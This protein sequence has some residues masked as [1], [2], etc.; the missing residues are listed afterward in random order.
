[1]KNRFPIWFSSLIIGLV[2]LTYLGCGN[3]NDAGIEEEDG[4]TSGS[5]DKGGTSTPEKP[6]A[7]SQEKAQ[8]A[9]ED[10]FKD[11]TQA[12]RFDDSDR[13]LTFV[14]EDY[15]YNFDFVYTTWQGRRFS[16]AKVID[17][18]SAGDLIKVRVSLEWPT[19]QRETKTQQL[20]K[21]K[22]KW[23]LLEGK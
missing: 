19:G 3:D 13:A 21:Q 11:F 12:L 14:A 9:A 20:K 22:R 8:E 1:M 15:K 17:I 5:K 6:P 2:S 16:G 23:V 18:N 4:K 7:L 10:F